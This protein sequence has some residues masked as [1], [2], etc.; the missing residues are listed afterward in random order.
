KG[1]YLPGER[2]PGVRKL[3]QEFAVSVSTIQEAYAVLVDEGLLRPRER[4]GFYVC[5]FMP[6]H[7]P[8][9]QVVTPINVAPQM[10][11]G[12]DL[13]L[14][15]IKQANRPG[16]VQ[17]GPAVPDPSYLPVAALQKS[18]LSAARKYPQ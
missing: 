8:L 10:I 16:V 14:T 5:D 6:K 17:F 3:A 13:T 7:V 11:S 2:L 1:I 9:P 4:S 15:M 12:Q 18:M